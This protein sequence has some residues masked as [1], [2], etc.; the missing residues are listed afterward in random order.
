MTGL[1]Y[2]FWVVAVQTTIGSRL[3]FIVWKPCPR[4]DYLFTNCHI[5]RF[6]L[7]YGPLNHVWEFESVPGGECRISTAVPFHT[8]IVKCLDFA[9][10]SHFL[11][12]DAD[13][14][15]ATQNSAERICLYFISKCDQST[16]FAQMVCVYSNLWRSN[17]QVQSFTSQ[18]KIK[19]L[20]LGKWV[21]IIKWSQ[22]TNQIC[23]N[24][25]HDKVNYI[26]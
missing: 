1:A 19:I 23:T 11:T 14:T 22:T 17:L 18:H 3:I 25:L 4:R 9:I 26:L 12:D 21:W 8:T 2:L 24:N 5:A 16:Y 13:G 10:F 20:I 15:T 6:L 7:T